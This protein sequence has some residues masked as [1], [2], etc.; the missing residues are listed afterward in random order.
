ML[1]QGLVRPY[2]VNKFYCF[3]LSSDPFQPNDSMVCALIDELPVYATNEPFVKC[4]S[5]KQ[6][7]LWGSGAYGMGYSN[8]LSID[9]PIEKYQFT[10][11]HNS[12][13]L[14]C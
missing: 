2:I 12:K 9:C 10:H 11:Q 5:P 6:M 14:T 3:Q 7:F 8:I 13:S 4:L 1:D